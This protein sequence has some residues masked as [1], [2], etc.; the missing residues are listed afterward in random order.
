MRLA[1]LVAPR[2]FR[3]LE[4][5]PPLRAAGELLVDVVACGV[6]ASELDQWDGSSGVEL[7]RRIG[8]EVSGTVTQADPGSAYAVGDP[9]AV[10]TP[11]SGYADQVSAPEASCRALGTFPVGLGLLEPVACAANAVELAGVRLADDVVI[12][13]AGFMGSLV[14]QL[15]ALRGA[16]SVTVVDRRPDV[17]AL[18]R[19][20]GATRTVDPRQESAADAVAAL[21]DGRGAD[22][23]F[24]VTGVQG[25]L[26][27]V[28]D[29]TRMSG[30]VVL[31]GFHL[32]APRTIPLG[33][34][35][36]MAYDLRNAHFRDPATIMRGMDVAGRLLAAGRLDLEPLVTH[37]FPLGRIDEA[38]ATAV[39]KPQGFVKAVVT[40]TEETAPTS[41]A[42]A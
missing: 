21:T 40:M 26:D 20:L 15:V 19:L 42:Q 33:H 8:H 11:G 39:A 28:G 3:V 14:Q 41:G 35:N 25:G 22:V 2:T 27:A 38:F 24:E 36:W 12:V 30:R 16:R 4:V 32:G 7:P 1:E 31:V 17:L 23:T 29:L 10:W 5:A 34:W 6:C 9:V 37:R 18:A 13:G